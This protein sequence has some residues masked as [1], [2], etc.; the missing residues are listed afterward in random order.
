MNNLDKNNILDVIIIGGGPAGI[1]AAIYGKR[2]GLKVNII[3]KGIIGGNIANTHL[4]ENYPALMGISGFEFSMKLEKHLKDLEIDFNIETVLNISRNESLSNE[5]G[6]NIFEIETNKNKY[7]SKNIIISTGTVPKSLNIPGEQEY[8]GKGV[9]YCATCD[10]MLYKK[11]DVA[12]VGGG[13]TALESITVLSEICNNVYVFVRGD[14][15]RGEQIVVDNILKKENVHIMYNTSLTEIKGDENF[16]TEISTTNGNYNIDGVFITIGTNPNS[17]LFKDL[18]SL[19]N[20]NE[21]ITD[22]QTME[23]S[24]KNIYAIGDVR[25]TKIRQILT[26]MSDAIY[27]I[28]DI[29]SNNSKLS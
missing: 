22:H 26:G 23:T 25:D 14:K 16:V 21:I 11:K 3:E 9:S 20:F 1:T 17:E 12:V 10:G 6:L 8:Y 13:N 28:H 18:V 7:F 27:A 19:N 4:I 15:F 2:S 29:I 24:F 5:I